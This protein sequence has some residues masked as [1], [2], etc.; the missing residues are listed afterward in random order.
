MKPWC[1]C[2]A[3]DLGVGQVVLD[4]WPVCAVILVVALADVTYRV[5]RRA[6]AGH[7]GSAEEVLHRL[8]A[9]RV[10]RLPVGVLERR[11][12]LRRLVGDAEQLGVDRR[13]AI[14][15]WGRGQHRLVPPVTRAHQHPG[16]PA[17]RAVER[18]TRLGE[19]RGG[20]HPADER[21]GPPAGGV[22][23]IQRLRIDGVDRVEYLAR[24]A[25]ALD[26]LGRLIPGAVIA[27]RRAESLEED[28]RPA[29]GVGSDAQLARQLLNR[30][31]LLRAVGGVGRIDGIR[32][33]A[34]QGQHL[35]VQHQKVKARDAT[36]GVRLR[37]ASCRRPGS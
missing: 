15:A 14:A 35:G 2:G 7:V 4:G 32:L 23:A 31:R 5:G 6:Q 11:E 8:R 34:G 36:A 3:L 30:G 12:G 25:E 17:G 29:G 26:L 33:I 13:L 19:R 9:R 28:Q 27:V 1:G 37:I 24:P 18:V 22:L 10:D 21:V 16:K 20:A